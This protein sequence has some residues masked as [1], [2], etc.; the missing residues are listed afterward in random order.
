MP[1]PFSAVA[2]WQLWTALTAHRILP[3]SKHGDWVDLAAGG[4]FWG[5]VGGWAVIA[6]LT[7]AVS[8]EFWLQVLMPRPASYRAALDDDPEDGDR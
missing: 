1:L 4:A 6:L 5:W 2:L 8:A 7:L 3:L